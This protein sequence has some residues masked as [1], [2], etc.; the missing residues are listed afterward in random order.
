MDIISLI[1]GLRKFGSFFTNN[2]KP[3]NT[4][5]LFELIL[6]IVKK[7]YNKIIPDSIKYR[8]INK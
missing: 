8:K 6:K 1:K 7:V 4:K 5:E 2:I 3:K